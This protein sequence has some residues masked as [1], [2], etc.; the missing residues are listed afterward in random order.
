MVLV[1]LVLL[2]V[3]MAFNPRLNTN[4]AK[5]AISVKGYYDS[6]SQLQYYIRYKLFSSLIFSY[7]TSRWT[8][9]YKV[10]HMSPLPSKHLLYCGRPSGNLL[11]QDETVLSVRQQAYFS[12]IVVQFVNKTTTI[13][14]ACGSGHCLELSK[15]W[16]K[17]SSFIG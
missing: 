16:I 8:D 17:S 4:M 3:H 15:N 10:M 12:T 11:V 14:T 7:M 9:R 2:V 13:A 5:L 6:K 1:L